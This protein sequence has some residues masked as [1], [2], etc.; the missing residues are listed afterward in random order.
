MNTLKLIA[1][2]V[3]RDL[4]GTDKKLEN[5]PAEERDNNSWWY[6]HGDL[7]DITGYD[8]AT[9]INCK[10]GGF[11]KDTINWSEITGDIVNSISE[12]IP[13]SQMCFTGVVDVEIEGIKEHCIGYFW[14]VN[15]RTIYWENKPYQYWEQRGLVCLKSDTKGC[16]YAKKKYE[17]KPNRL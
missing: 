15:H 3:R 9:T 1:F 16:E 7:T 8:K 17:E 11:S 5:I 14:T 10:S 6:L 12:D 2:S 13:T 4:I